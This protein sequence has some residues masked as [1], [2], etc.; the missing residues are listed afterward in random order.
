MLTC[1]LLALTPAAPPTDPPPPVA[2]VVDLTGKPTRAGG[3]GKPV[4]VFRLDLLR[5]GDAVEAGDGASVTLLFV[6]DGHLEVVKPRSQVKATEKGCN[7]EAAV[8][9]H[10]GKL[11]GE[12]LKALRDLV[13][14]GK[15]GIAVFRLQFDAPPEMIAPIEDAIV[16]TDRPGFRWLGVAGAKEY[17]FDLLPADPKA[18]EPLWTQKTAGTELAYPKER[19]ALKRLAA[20]RW[21]ATAIMPNGD[22]TPVIKEGRFIIGTAATQKKA[23]ALAELAKSGDRADLLV[24]AAGYEALRLL[25]E[26]YPLYARLA[27]QAADDPVMWAKAGEYAFR[28][29]RAKAAEAAWK[30]ARD[31]G[32]QPPKPGEEKP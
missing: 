1:L 24:A 18:T 7:P 21:R 19:P 6:S 30:M 12:D 3:D 11:T 10:P 31:L 9:K 26:L 20:Y 28:S 5:P 8:E 25:D 15:M 29:G 16:A 27:E 17:R 23:A 32:W 14:S 2:V 13:R 22:E 4:P